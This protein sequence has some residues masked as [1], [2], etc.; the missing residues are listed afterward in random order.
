MRLR[1]VRGSFRLAV[2]AAPADHRHVCGDDAS[3]PSDPLPASHLAASNS[4]SFSLCVLLI[5]VL[6]YKLA[7]PKIS[8]APHCGLNRSAVHRSSET[9]VAL[10]VMMPLIFARSAFSAGRVQM[11]RAGSLA[12]MAP[13]T[14]ILRWLL[15]AELHFLC[16]WHCFLTSSFLGL[17]LLS[18]LRSDRQS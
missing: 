10:A 11:M 5:A 3:H 13:A 12:M 14:R 9:T 18:Y 16:F 17:V 2:L 6:H 7:R 8:S 1:S 15:I 4:I